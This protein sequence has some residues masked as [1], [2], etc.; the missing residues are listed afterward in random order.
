MGDYGSRWLIR[1]RKKQ[2]LGENVF[3]DIHDYIVKKSKGVAYSPS[4]DELD[5][6]V[7]ALVDITLISR[8]QYLITAGK[9]TFPEWIAARFLANHRNDKHAWSKITI[10][11]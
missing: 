1:Y 5:R 10:C 3:K 11:T 6:G 9:G 4:T 7:I 2:N 8:A